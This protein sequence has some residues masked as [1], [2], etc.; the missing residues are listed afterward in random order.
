VSW[1]LHVA[2]EKKTYKWLHDEELKEP[3]PLPEFYKGLQESFTDIAH[4]GGG[5]MVALERTDALVRYLLV[6]TF[7]PKWEKDMGRVARGL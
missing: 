2:H 1:P 3:S 5:E 7:G 4:Q 6:Q